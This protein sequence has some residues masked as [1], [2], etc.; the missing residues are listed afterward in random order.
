MFRSWYEDQTFPMH[1]HTHKR[2]HDERYR[3]SF[4][5][6]GVGQHPAGT[7]LFEQMEIDTNNAD[8]HPSRPA[9][10]TVEILTNYNLRAKSFA[11]QQAILSLRQ[12]SEKAETGSNISGSTIEELTNALITD[13]PP[14]VARAVQRDELAALV[15]LQ[16]LVAR[17]I[18]VLSQGESAPELNGRRTSDALTDIDDS[19]DGI[20]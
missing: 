9:G 2:M 11:E 17:R 4:D 8:F 10:P 6:D 16:N 18:S 7:H 15:N 13:A 5:L 20:S 19:M 3:P 1:L 14:E 12:L